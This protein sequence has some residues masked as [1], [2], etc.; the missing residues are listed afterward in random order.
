M[1]E[2]PICW[3]TDAGMIPNH[4]GVHIRAL[5]RDVGSITEHVYVIARDA[6]GRHFLSTD[7]TLLGELPLRLVV[8]WRAE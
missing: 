1:H 7:G 8:A 4:E 6:D 5:A 2:L 3:N